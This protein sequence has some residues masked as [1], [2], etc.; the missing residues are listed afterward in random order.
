[1]TVEFFRPDRAYEA[2]REELHA[3]LEE[4]LTSRRVILGPQ[5]EQFEREFAEAAGTRFAIGVASGTDALEIA[6]RALEL[7]AGSGSEVLCP[8]LTAVATATAIVRA[9]LAPVFVDVDPET[10]TVS[11]ERAAA[12][13]TPQTSAVVA[14]HLYGRPAPVEALTELGIPVVEDC[15]QAHGLEIGGRPAGSLGRLGAFSFYPT[16]NLG[17]FG[18]GGT[19]TTSDSELAERVRSLRVYG[20]DAEGRATRPGL[21]S[22]LDELQAALLRVRL[23]RLQRDNE[24][25]AEIARTYD[26]AL[27]R[28]SP[29]GVHHLYVA[30]SQSRDDAR[31]QLARGGIETAVHYPFAL[32]DH[33]A[34]AGAR[35]GGPL[36]TS[37]A[38]A[39][40]VLSLPCYPHLS[41][42][43]EERVAAELLRLGAV[44]H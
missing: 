22:R 38:A 1:V 29:P 32:T 28:P 26:A 37:E 11:V 20:E 31:A 16:K 4:V 41:A 13:I 8:N 3:A 40:E 19:V 30:R 12:A 27:G 10:L 25:R 9:G 2:Q 18:D 14:V 44:L 35:R 7:P 43:E 39:R 6:L 42:E 5:V 15:A 17:A 33:P 24:R 34:F 23:R 21:N 36:A